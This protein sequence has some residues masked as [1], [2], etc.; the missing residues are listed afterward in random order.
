M[1]Q[2]HKDTNFFIYNF[3]VTS[4]LCGCIFCVK[5]GLLRL[6]R[7]HVSRRKT[8]GQAA[9]KEGDKAQNSLL[10]R[11]NYTNFAH[12]TNYTKKKRFCNKYFYWNLGG[13]VRL[14]SP[15]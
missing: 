7:R 14:R 11:T 9:Q 8:R 15:F 12:K 1:P 10:R 2:R 3:F 4:R 6:A 5:K 13:V